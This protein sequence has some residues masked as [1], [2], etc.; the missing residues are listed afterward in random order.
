MQE[1][2]RRGVMTLEEELVKHFSTEESSLRNARRQAER[3]LNNKGVKTKYQGKKNPFK[4]KK[5]E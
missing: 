5:D 3:V 4:S 2:D 1:Q